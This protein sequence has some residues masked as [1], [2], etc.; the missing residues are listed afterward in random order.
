ME[1]A[2]FEV[3]SDPPVF[4]KKWTYMTEFGT[5]GKAVFDFPC[6]CGQ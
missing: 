5:V 2:V 1:K 3:E 4:R 6:S